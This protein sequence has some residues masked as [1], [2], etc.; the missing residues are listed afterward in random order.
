MHLADCFVKAWRK[1]KIT[2]NAQKVLHL[3]HKAPKQFLH[4]KFLLSEIDNNDSQHH[5]EIKIE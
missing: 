5:L 4:F 2:K 1:Q 3:N